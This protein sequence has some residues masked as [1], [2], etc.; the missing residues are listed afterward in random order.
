VQLA[1]KKQSQI[2]PGIGCPLILGLV[3]LCAYLLWTLISTIVSDWRSAQPIST[4]HIEKLPPKEKAM[5]A[6]INL[7]GELCSKVEL[8]APT[9]DPDEFTVFCQEYGNP[10]KSGTKKN[11]AVYK[12]NMNSAIATLLGRG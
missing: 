12:V 2:P 1:V 3:A 6:L 11:M 8:I 9:T 5:A 10:R 7:N 4:P